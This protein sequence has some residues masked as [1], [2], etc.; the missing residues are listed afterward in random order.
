MPYFDT[1]LLGKYSYA[2][3][4]W[5]TAG[6][7]NTLKLICHLKVN[8]NNGNFLYECNMAHYCII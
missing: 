4:Y 2:L 1:H 6:A 8:V 3:K 5:C 7:E